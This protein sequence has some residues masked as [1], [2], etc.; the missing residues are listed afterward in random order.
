[1]TDNSQRAKYVNLIYYVKV[2]NYEEDDILGNIKQAFKTISL[3]FR[4]LHLRI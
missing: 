1:M 2:I 4:L 3:L